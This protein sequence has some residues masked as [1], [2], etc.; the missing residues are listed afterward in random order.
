M[1][2][3]GTLVEVV[4]V[5]THTLHRCTGIAICMTFYTSNRRMRSG[6]REIGETVI[7]ATIQI[8]WSP[9][10]FGMTSYTVGGEANLL[11]VR[12]AGLVVIILVATHAGIRSIGIAV[13]MAL[14]TVIC[15][16]CM[17]TI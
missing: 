10:I 1:I 6:Q 8:H 16:Q 4:L 9:R 17:C 11:V 3:I 13:G 2:R 15:D 14:G 7:K 5:A 12:S